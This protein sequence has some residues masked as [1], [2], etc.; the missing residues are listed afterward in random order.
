MKENK[1]VMVWVKFEKIGFHYY[2]DAPSDVDYLKSKHRHKF[3]FK[4]GVKVEHDD[5]EVEF[6]QLLNFCL[7]GFTDEIIDINGKSCEMLADDIYDHLQTSPIYCNRKTI[8]DVSE[9]NEVGAN[10]VYSIKET[11]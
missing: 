7:S 3:Y 1:E 5:R 9:D 2:K 8:I 6:H 4:V 11:I 10:C